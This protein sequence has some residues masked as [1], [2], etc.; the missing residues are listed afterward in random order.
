MKDRVYYELKKHAGEY[1][2]GERL[3]AVLGV[4]RTAVWKYI[5][6]L[7]ADG[8][9]I[10]ASSRKGYRLAE[11]ADILSPAALGFGLSTRRIGR[12]IVCLDVVDSTNNQAK[13]LAAEGCAE[14]TVVVAD[15]QVS[16][17]GRL[18]RSWSSPA[19]TG[20]WMSVVLRPKIPPEEVQAI[21]LAASVAVCKA[22]GDT[23]GIEAGIKW[24]NDI[25]LDGKKVCG[26]LTEMNSE[27]ERVNF[28]VLGIGVNVNQKTADFPVEL[29]DTATSLRMYAENTGAVTPVFKRNE[30]IKSILSELEKVYE[31]V[32]NGRTDNVLKEWQ[33]YTVTLGRE[34][35]VYARNCTYQGRAT[36]ITA[37]GK[38]IVECEDGVVREVLSGE[39][40]IRSI[41]CLKGER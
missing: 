30:L 28:I 22:I 32:E 11:E 36:G 2:S 23:T 39:V 8:F 35:M 31:S 7:R 26:I 27:M 18:G 1:V 3:S 4:S 12:N 9:L 14:G 19:K 24:P 25:L 38:L 29:R 34:V 13:K 6:E 21:T 40:S 10:E 33:K 15:R 17:K 37:D 5:R 16:G 20:I 41:P